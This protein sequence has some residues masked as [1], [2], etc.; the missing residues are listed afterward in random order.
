MA[1][2]GHIHPDASCDAALKRL[3]GALEGLVNAAAKE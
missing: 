2:L 3:S 1:T